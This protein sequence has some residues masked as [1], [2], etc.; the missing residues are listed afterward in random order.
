ME[1]SEDLRPALTLGAK[2][3]NTAVTTAQDQDGPDDAYAQQQCIQSF[4]TIPNKGRPGYEREMFGSFDS[5]IQEYL[6]LGE[7][8]EP[9][10]TEYVPSCVD[11]QLLS[12]EDS[13]ANDE[14]LVVCMPNLQTDSFLVRRYRP[15]IM[16]S[17][18]IFA[19]E[20]PK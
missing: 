11:D 7:S 20:G 4:N 13:E 9:P 5:G 1:A 12:P 18:N 16:W 2:F 10:L 3:N 19:R 15:D 17:I 6:G 8:D 14:L